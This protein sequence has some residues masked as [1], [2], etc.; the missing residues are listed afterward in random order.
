V[1]VDAIYSQLP[2]VPNIHTAVSVGMLGYV[3]NVNA[4]LKGMNKRLKKGAR[5]CFV[6]YDKFFDII[7]NVEWLSDDKKI[8]QFKNIIH[9][10]I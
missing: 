1:F 9:N 6:D 10:G 7:P 5:V 2:S 4:V 3:Q 8:K